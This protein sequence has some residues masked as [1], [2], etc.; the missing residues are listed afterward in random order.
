MLIGGSHHIVKFLMRHHCGF[1]TWWVV[2]LWLLNAVIRLDGCWWR[3]R[4]RERLGGQLGWWQCW[5]W[6]L[7]TA[8]VSQSLSR[9]TTWS[10]SRKITDSFALLLATYCIVSYHSIRCRLLPLCPLLYDFSISILRKLFITNT[11]VITFNGLKLC[12]WCCCL[13]A[14]LPHSCIYCGCHRKTSAG[15]LFFIFFA[16]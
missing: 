12:K 5:G 10:F 15:T 3:S 6:F 14:V 9:L 16:K 1:R 13:I 4:W 11:L 8:A 7:T 2:K